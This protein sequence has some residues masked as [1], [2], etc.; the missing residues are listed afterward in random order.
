MKLGEVYRCLSFLHA[1]ERFYLVSPFVSLI[2]TWS[3]LESPSAPHPFPYARRPWLRVVNLPV[4]EWRFGSLRISDLEHL[5][6]SPW[7]NRDCEQAQGT[8]GPPEADAL[9]NSTGYRRAPV[10]RVGDDTEGRWGR[11]VWSWRVLRYVQ[12]FIQN[13]H[14]FWYWWLIQNSCSTDLLAAKNWFPSLNRVDETWWNVRTVQYLAIF[15]IVVSLFWSSVWAFGIKG[16]LF[17]CTRCTSPPIRSTLVGVLSISHPWCRAGVTLPQAYQLSEVLEAVENEM[18]SNIMAILDIA[19]GCAG[20]QVLSLA[21][22]LSLIS[23]LNWYVH[24]QPPR[25]KVWHK[26]STS[27]SRSA[28]QGRFCHLPSA[29]AAAAELKS[30]HDMSTMH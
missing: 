9:I 24:V 3:G 7:T 1:I 2:P 26:I 23:S 29:H 5:G 25:C 18:P 12:S 15:A 10:Q 22:P 4:L 19:V 17:R 30:S 14:A 28:V 13:I 11:W 6:S 8:R 20:C 21:T 27:E 16:K